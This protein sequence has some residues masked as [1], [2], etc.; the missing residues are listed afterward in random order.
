MSKMHDVLISIYKGMCQLVSLLYLDISEH[1]DQVVRAAA[2]RQVVQDILVHQ[3]DV[4][5]PQPHRAIGI[6]TMDNHSYKQNALLT[7]HPQIDL[8][9]DG[10]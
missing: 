2:Q 3:L 1:L 5:V 8:L 6:P 10:S 9:V 7:D 4:R